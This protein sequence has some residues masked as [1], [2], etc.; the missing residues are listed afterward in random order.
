[1]VYLIIN[2][3]SGPLFFSFPAGK[4]MQKFSIHA[5]ICIPK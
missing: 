3:E 1:L 4:V 5:I 2:V